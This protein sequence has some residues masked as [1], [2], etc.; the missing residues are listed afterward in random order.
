MSFW[1]FWRKKRVYALLLLTFLIVLFLSSSYV[2][3]LLYPIPYAQEIRQNA[4][5]YQMDPFLIAAVMRVE[6]NF[7][8]GTQSK[9]GAYG[10]MQLMPDTSDWIIEKGSFNDSYRKQLDVPA[11]S[12]ELGTW[13][14][15]WMHKQ[16]GGNTTAV[17]AGYNAG[18]GKVSRWL[19]EHEWD[20]TLQNADMIPYGE[21]RH[22]VQRV[23]YYY[24]KYHK[25]YADEWQSR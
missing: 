23:T 19:Q 18:H 14:L 25:L 13:Y 22:Y 11:V 4:V 1:S 2:G 3:R 8:V 21:T 15:S 12:I 6:S 20:G 7:Q 17:I 16:F 9:K 24:N 5:K 10:L